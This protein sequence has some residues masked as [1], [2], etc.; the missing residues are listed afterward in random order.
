MGYNEYLN[1]LK[2]H[3]IPRLERLDREVAITKE[4]ALLSIQ[5]L[6]DTDITILGGD[7][8]SL[9]SDGYLRPTYDNWSYAG[10]NKD[11]SHKKAYEYIS[12]YHEKES[13]DIR[14]ILVLKSD[15]VYEY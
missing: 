7:V 10:N 11:E 1:V 13:L 12:S 9:E 5:M 15:E 4:Y 8:C 2:E 3:G 6:E 14:Y